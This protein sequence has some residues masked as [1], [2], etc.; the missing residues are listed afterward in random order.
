MTKLEI[1]LRNVVVHRVPTSNPINA[2]LTQIMDM[3]LHIHIVID[4]CSNVSHAKILRQ[5]I[6][7]VGVAVGVNI[8]LEG[9]DDVGIFGGGNC[10]E[11]HGR[12]IVV[13]EVDLFLSL[14]VEIE[15]VAPTKFQDVDVLI[16]AGLFEWYR[17]VKRRNSKFQNMPRQVIS[18]LGLNAG[19]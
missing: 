11:K 3:C 10:C 1:V 12:S 6:L 13:G 19:R 17:G 5:E 15:L 4:E 7:V 18:V 9:G 8:R 14:E 16:P 2:A